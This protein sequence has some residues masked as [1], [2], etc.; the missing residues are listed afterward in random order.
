ML[1]FFIGAHDLSYAAAAGIVFA[2]NITSS[3]VQPLFGHAADKFAKPWMLSIGLML[4]GSGLTLTGL[5]QSYRWISKEI[6]EK[7]NY[8]YAA[9]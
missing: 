9:L 7:Q 8:K 6:W 1:P 3:I 4:A 5:F 2:A